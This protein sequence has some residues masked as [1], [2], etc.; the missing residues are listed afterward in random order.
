MQSQPAWFQARRQAR[1]WRW[2]LGEDEDAPWNGQFSDRWDNS[3][4]VRPDADPRGHS[5]AARAN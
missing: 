4:I 1:K 3:G 5:V 2:H